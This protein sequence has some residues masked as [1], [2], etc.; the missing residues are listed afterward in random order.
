MAS[1]RGVVAASMRLH[2]WRFGFKQYRL[3]H[4]ARALRD[5]TVNAFRWLPLLGHC[6]HRPAHNHLAEQILDNRQIQPP[7]TSCNVGHICHPLLVRGGGIKLPI[8]EI[9]GNRLRVVRVGCVPIFPLGFRSNPCFSHDPGHCVHAAV[10]APIQQ[11]RVHPRAAVTCFDLGVDRLDQH[12]Q[13]IT[14]FFLLATRPIT[15]EIIACLGYVQ[16]IADSQDKSLSIVLVNNA[17]AHSDYL[18]KKTV[19]FLKCRVRP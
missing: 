4:I 5:G 16:C 18:A 2:R 19:D 9:F 8:Q 1:P 3:R 7:F 6:V 17:I 13:Q 15:P 10:V 11:L 12:G 14:L